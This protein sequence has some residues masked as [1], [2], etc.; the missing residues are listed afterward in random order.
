MAFNLY[1]VA[2]SVKF[3]DDTINIIQEGSRLGIVRT[4][5]NGHGRR[6]E[7]GRMALKYVHLECAVTS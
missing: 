7:P 4:I 1:A 3:L 2:Q 6:S 5:A